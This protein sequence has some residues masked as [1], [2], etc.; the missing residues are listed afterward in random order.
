MF[1]DMNCLLIFSPRIRRVSLQ[2]HDQPLGI[3]F[4]RAVTGK[5]VVTSPCGGENARDVVKGEEETFVATPLGE[6]GEL[7]QLRGALFVLA[8]LVEQQLEQVDAT[9]A[10]KLLLVARNRLRAGF[11]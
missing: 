9:K 2:R 4:T 10:L 5:T 3:L 1:F 8:N 6:L 7:L 11:R